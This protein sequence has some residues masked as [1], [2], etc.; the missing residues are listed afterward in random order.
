MVLFAGDTVWSISERVRGVCVD[1]LYKSTYTLL[2]LY[3]D[4]SLGIVP[5]TPTIVITSSPFTKFNFCFAIYPRLYVLLLR[6]SGWISSAAAENHAVWIIL[7]SLTQR[8]RWDS[9]DAIAQCWNDLIAN[10]RTATVSLFYSWVSIAAALRA[11]ATPATSK[12]YRLPLL[13]DMLTNS[14]HQ[15]SGSTPRI[16]QT[17]EVQ[18]NIHTFEQCP[19]SFWSSSV[20]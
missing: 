14:P 16:K 6:G 11:T 10:D 2:L 20:M 15:G 8:R 5:T 3:F 12:G 1:A 4:T 18:K 9:C 13:T 7:Y 17:G 19:N